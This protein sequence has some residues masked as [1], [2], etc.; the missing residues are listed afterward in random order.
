MVKRLVVPLKMLLVVGMLITWLPMLPQASVLAQTALNES[1]DSGTLPQGW[2]LIRYNNTTIDWSFANPGN[3]TNQTG[4]TGNFAIIDSDHANRVPVD[5]ELQTPQLDFRGMATVRLTFRSYFRSYEQTSENINVDVSGDGGS[6]WTTVYG[7]ADSQSGLVTLDISAQAANKSNVIVAFHYYN[8]NYSWYW[9]IDDVK[10]E[11]IG[12]PAA[13]TNLSASTNGSQ[14]ALSWTD[15]SSN[16]TSF[17]VERATSSGAPFA[18]ISGTSRDSTTYAD[19][20]GLS[21]NTTYYYRVRSR[22]ASGDSAYSNVANATTAA[23]AGLSTL[24]ESFTATSAPPGWTTTDLSNGSG[25]TW[26]FDDAAQRQFLGV[27]SNNLVN[28]GDDDFDQITVCHI[29]VEDVA[30]GEWLL[31]GTTSEPE[32]DMLYWIRSVIDKD[33]TSTFQAYIELPHGEVVTYPEPVVVRASVAQQFPVT[34]IT[35]VATVE[36]DY[37]ITVYFDNFAGNGKFSEYSTEFA[38][39]PD[40]TTR[41]PQLTLVGQDFQRF[42]ET[43]VNV[44]G[45]QEDDHA[46]W[47]DASPTALSRRL[48]AGI[49]ACHCRTNVLC[50]GVSPLRGGRDGTLPHQCRSTH[51]ERAGFSIT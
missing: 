19:S 15:A 1:F 29:E 17:R 41:D 28:A 18:E 21:C 40:G 37:L 45:V 38:P 34:D 9:Q 33:D 49:G 48:P 30:P 13:P 3:R 5:A 2:R 20:T 14:I 32:V 4:G 12:A 51:C 31:F 46:D 7:K 25:A 44:V 36:G 47:F 22:N 8:A 42:A 11:G 26:N 39:S 16:E 43:Q 27:G 23:C 35:V 10:I 24:N 50:R 6:T